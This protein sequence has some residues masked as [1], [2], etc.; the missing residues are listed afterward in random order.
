M[1]AILRQIKQN[2]IDLNWDFISPHLVGFE[3]GLS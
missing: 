1:I 2:S 3:H